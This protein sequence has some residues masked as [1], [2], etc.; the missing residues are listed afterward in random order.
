MKPSELFEKLKI[1][2]KNIPPATIENP[3]D[4]TGDEIKR[5]G[6]AFHDALRQ[7]R[8]SP[9]YSAVYIKSERMVYSGYCSLD[10]LYKYLANEG[11]ILPPN[12]ISKIHK[13]LADEGVLVPRPNRPRI[14][15]LPQRRHIFIG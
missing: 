3:I 8:P 15:P 12:I 9:V 10:D 5:I 13:E 11:G 7:P 1:D 4:P 14:T 2:P 6:Q